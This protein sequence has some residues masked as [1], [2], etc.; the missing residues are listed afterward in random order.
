MK[1]RTIK[2]AVDSIALVLGLIGIGFIIWNLFLFASFKIPSMSMY[3]TLQPGDKILVDKITTGARIFDIFKAAKGQKLKIRRT[4]CLRKIKRGDCVVFNSPFRDNWEKLEMDYH[5]YYAKRC[6]GIPGDI[7]EI[8]NFRYFI[9]GRQYQERINFECD[10]VQYTIDSIKSVGAKGFLAMRKNRLTR[11]TIENLGPLYIP[12]R[13][14]ILAINPSNFF[15]YK[16]VIEWESGKK[17][18]CENNEIKLDG[19]TIEYYKFKGNYYFMAGDNSTN[20]Q[21][22]RYW[23]FVPEQ[24]IVGRAMLIWWSSNSKRRFKNID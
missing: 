5:T 12:K 17:L 7:I 18:K 20:S 2:R 8:K 4:P 10:E 1:L 11:W 9:N 14:D 13:N 21:D 22:S 15:P 6:M 19:K 16:K 23:G 3:P 24:F